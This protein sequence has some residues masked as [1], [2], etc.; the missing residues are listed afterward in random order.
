MKVP[1][2]DSEK[3]AIASSSVQLRKLPRFSVEDLADGALR[4]HYRSEREGLAPIVVGLLRG[5]AGRFG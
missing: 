5:L 3:A 4:V 1:S 2:S